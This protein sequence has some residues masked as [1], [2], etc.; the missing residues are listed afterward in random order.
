M[1]TDERHKTSTSTLQYKCEEPTGPKAMG[2]RLLGGY[3]PA[4]HL[5]FLMLL[6]VLSQ[7]ASAWYEGSVPSTAG[8]YQF[9]MGQHQQ[10]QDTWHRLLVPGYGEHFPQ[11]C[12]SAQ[13]LAGPLNS[14]SMDFNQ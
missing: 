11:V 6:L 7:D 13:I 4:L 9:V 12:Q 10:L 8:S 3:L 2:G 1:A 14:L 5:S